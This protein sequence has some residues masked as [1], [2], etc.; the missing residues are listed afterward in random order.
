MKK[1]L[2]STIIASTLFATPS[3]SSAQDVTSTIMA[4]HTLEQSN[5]IEASFD[6]KDILANAVKVNDNQVRVIIQLHD[7]PLAQFSGVNPTIRSASAQQG[8]KVDFS[9][10]AATA[11]KKI[12]KN[13]QQSLIEDIH[14]F[15][16]NFEAD[17]S[18][19]AS[20]NGVSGIANKHALDNLAEF[21]RSESHLS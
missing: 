4:S 16:S 12:L 21:A 1:K 5:P 14:T 7:S 19:T 15:D 8:M 17:K 18:F 11:Y 3:L 20:F 10:N 9:S 2:L 6:K 13:K